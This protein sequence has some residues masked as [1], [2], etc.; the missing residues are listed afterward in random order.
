MIK[1]DKDIKAPKRARKAIAKL[2]TLVEY[3]EY[4]IGKNNKFFRDVIIKELASSIE[5]ALHELS[6]EKNIDH[7]K[8][9][10]KLKTVWKKEQQ[11]LIEQEIEERLEEAVEQRLDDIKEISKG[12][13]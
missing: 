2:H 5:D 10:A 9:A 11:S 7:I 12:D 3:L 4:Y 1:K 6:V 8:L 13:L